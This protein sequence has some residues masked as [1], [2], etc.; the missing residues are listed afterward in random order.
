MLQLRAFLT[1]IRKSGL[2]LN[3]KKCSFAKPE[4]KFLGH[5]VGSGRHRPD[6][7]SC[8]RLLICRVLLVCAKC[9]GHLVFSLI[10][11]PTFPMLRMLRMTYQIWWRKINLTECYGLKKRRN[12]ISEIKTSIVYCTRRNLFTLQFGKPVGLHVDASN[13]PLVLI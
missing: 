11:V 2:T 1:E 12:R 10:F 5:V 6:E 13:G 9:A 7:D 8:L 3:L 4:V